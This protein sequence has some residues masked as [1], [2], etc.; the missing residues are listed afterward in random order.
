MQGRISRLEEGK[1][2]WQK[3]QSRVNPLKMLKFFTLF[4]ALCVA[5]T[6]LSAHTPRY[7]DLHTMVKRAQSASPLCHDET[8]S[9]QQWITP[10]SNLTHAM[11]DEELLWR[12]S[13]LPQV[14][15]YPYKRVPKV[16]FMFLSKGP[17]P[18]SHLWEK[19]FAGHQGLYSIYI[20]TLPDYRPDFPPTSVFHG[21][22]I[23]SQVTKKEFLLSRS[24]GVLLLLKLMVILGD[25]VGEDEHV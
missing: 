2:S 18:L 20:H 8:A 7:L 9:L 13:F 24:I 25:G 4:I 14:A 17:L 16:A 22:Q 19:F 12:A 5:A 23:P 15:T 21:R 3:T 10:P 11:T 6:I 1:D